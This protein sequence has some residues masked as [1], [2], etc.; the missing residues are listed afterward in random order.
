MV[1]CISGHTAFIYDRG[2][3]RRI[4]ELK[5]ISSIRW[6]RARDDTSEASLRLEAD[7]CAQQA[8]LI[9]MLRTKRHE[10]IIF[11][12]QDR[13]WEGPLWR[14]SVHA[15]YV[16]ITAK[17]ASQYLYGTP[18]SVP[19]S[20]R[21]PN[22]T[23]VTDRIG[24]IIEY[25]MTHD[26]TQQVYDPDLGDWVDVTVPAWESLDPPAN[27]VP[28]LDIRHFPNE[29]ETAMSTVAYE[30]TVGEHLEGLARQQ[31]IDW[32]TVGRSVI[33]WDVSRS[34]G[35]LPQMT[36]DNFTSEVVVTE[37]G[38]DHAQ[39]AYVMGQDESYG[40]AINLDNL[41]FYGPW[42]Q[43][44]T[45]YDEDGSETPTQ[46]VLNSQASRNLAGRSPAPIEVRVPDNSGILLDDTITIQKLV[47]GVQIPLRAT[48]NARPMSQLQK[49]D[50]LVVIETGTGG[51]QIQVTLTPATKPDFD[52]EEP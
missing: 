4:D 45:P 17:D 49:L 40:Q 11:R 27:V 48:L 42:T 51:E 7:S 6:E 43:V 12:G 52:T 13:V 14:I 16:E 36:E 26:R 41:D 5:D 3:M 18:L 10:L 25:E 23:T 8:D 38:A 2:G 47:P 28:Y 50:H 1:Q 30:M 9:A 39:A 29:A 15:E 34:L 33:V 22:E 37:Y 44:Y 35:R 21:Y 31:G 19:W 24:G 46:A 20:N 32:T